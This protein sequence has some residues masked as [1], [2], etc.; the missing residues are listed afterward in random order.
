V[1]CISVVVI[2]FEEK[3]N[4]ASFGDAYRQYKKAVPRWLGRRKKEDA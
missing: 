4:E 1:A 2:P 3:E